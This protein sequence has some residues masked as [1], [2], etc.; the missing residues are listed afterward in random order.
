MLDRDSRNGKANA[1]RQCDYDT[2]VIGTSRAEIAMATD[3]PRLS[4]KKAYNAALKGGSMYEMRRMAEYAM[5][6]QDLDAV[7]LSLDFISQMQPEGD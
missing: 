6:H 1:L 4:D 3:H 7:L 2:V 5:L